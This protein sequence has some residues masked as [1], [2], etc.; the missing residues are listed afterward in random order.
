MKSLEEYEK[1]REIKLKDIGLINGTFEEEIC[2][3]RRY[4]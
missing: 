2:E 3:G 1:K 4:S